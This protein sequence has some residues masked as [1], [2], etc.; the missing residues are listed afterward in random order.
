MISALPCLAKARRTWFSLINHALD[1][2][3]PSDVPLDLSGSRRY[4]TEPPSVTESPRRPPPPPPKRTLSYP[5]QCRSTSSAIPMRTR[6][7]ASTSTVRGAPY[8]SAYLLACC[9]YAIAD[10]TVRAQTPSTF[11]AT[12]TATSGAFAT[13]T[14]ATTRAAPSSTS[15]S[16]GSR[17]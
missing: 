11:R 8:A 6:P 4:L 7:F 1:C 10:P 9:T 12:S 3:K 5:A 14:R 13:Y 15:T 16:R 17:S 2:L